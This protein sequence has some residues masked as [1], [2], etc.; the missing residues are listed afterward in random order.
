M[1]PFLFQ[2]PPIHQKRIVN[3]FLNSFILKT[4]TFLEEFAN[5]CEDKLLQFE[6]KLRQVD[7]QLKLI[8]A[9]LESVPAVQTTRVVEGRIENVK[10][11]ENETKVEEKI[12]VVEKVAVE[13]PASDPDPVPVEQTGVK[14]KDDYRYKKYFKMVHFGVPPAAIKVSKAKDI[15]FIL[16]TNLF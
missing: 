11:V 2:V 1:K 14:A 16:R 10:E 7:T 9:K 8:E 5:Q 6:V 4:A 12:E 15:E 3:A 13:E